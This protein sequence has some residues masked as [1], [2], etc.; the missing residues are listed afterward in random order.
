MIA[1]PR[2]YLYIYE[3]VIG[4]IKSTK[5]PQIKISTNNINPE[6]FVISI[7]ILVL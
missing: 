4:Y 1:I 5:G 7:N 2:G 6:D 3:I